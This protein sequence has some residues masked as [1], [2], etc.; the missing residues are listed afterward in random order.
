MHNNSKSLFII[1]VSMLILAPLS[2]GWVV[3]SFFNSETESAE[4]QAGEGEEFGLEDNHFEKLEEERNVLVAPTPEDSQGRGTID[5]K[6]SNSEGIPIGKY[7]NPPTS[8]DSSGSSNFSGNRSID[9]FDSSSRPLDDFDSSIER[10]RS[11]QQYTNRMTPD[12]NTPNTESSSNNF[13]STEDNSLVEPLEEDV[14]E[15]PESDDDEQP[16]GISP[17]EEPLSPLQQ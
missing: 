12:Y 9:D 8:L 17:L 1:G 16:T 3:Y 5:P 6:E 7:S 13:N 11:R 10:N 14:L 15:I 2:G 4:E